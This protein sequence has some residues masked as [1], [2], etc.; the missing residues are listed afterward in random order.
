MRIATVDAVSGHTITAT[1]SLEA[2]RTPTKGAFVK[3]TSDADTLLG[4]VISVDLTNMVHNNPTFGPYIMQHGAVPMWSGDVD[5][6]C[7][8][9]ELVRSVDAYGN[10]IALRR[11]PSSGTPIE[12][13]T[14]GDLELFY[15]ERQR[16]L[17]LGCIPNSGQLPAAIINRHFGAWEDGGYGEARHTAIFGESGSGKTVLATMQ[18]AGRLAANPAMGLFMPDT[19]GDLSD[20]SRHDRGAF[21][22][23]YGTVLEAAGIRVE[24]LSISDVRLTSPAT[25]REKL[26]PVF[27][28]RL[29]MAEDK[30]TELSRL[31][32]TTIIQGSKVTLEEFTA[33]RVLDPVIELVGRLYTQQTARQKQATATD[34]RDTPRFRRHFDADIAG[35]ASLFDGREEIGHLIR[36]VLERGRKIIV[37]V[38][39]GITPTDQE[40]V[41]R[42]VMTELGWRAARAYRERG[43]HSCNALVVLDEGQRWIPQDAGRDNDN[44]GRLIQGHLRETRKYGLGWMV[45]AQSPTGI[46]NE[47]LRQAHTT[48]FGR[49]LGIGAD[50][51]H[52]EQN[53]GSNGGEAY[54]QLELQ[55]GFFWVAAGHDNNIGTESS[56]FSFHPFG[57][58]ATAAFIAANPGIFEGRQQRLR[59]QAG[60]LT[61]QLDFTE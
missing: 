10:F 19:A 40:F 38:R 17:L 37:N 29:A 3:L 51:K 13:L 39:D 50:Q 55:G 59:P 18:I 11:N 21:R 44:I 33:D 49:G 12:S 56:Y 8:K 20:P 23:N 58:D 4:R 32:V 15:N 52:L 24:H 9:I 27:K 26:V 28:S 43:N 35:I 31:V 57:G 16:L 47:V 2:R 14:V 48:Y 22:W 42:E 61:R 5:I 54:K 7:A 34:L 53:L 45:V 25:L 36:G 41:M 60:A 1:L 6:E 30:A 46:H